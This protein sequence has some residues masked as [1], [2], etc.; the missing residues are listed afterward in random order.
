M[1]GLILH[2]SPSKHHD[3][4]PLIILEDID[5]AEILIIEILHK[6]NIPLSYILIISHIVIECEW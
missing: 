5:I 1:G 3:V 2:E 4:L 6:F